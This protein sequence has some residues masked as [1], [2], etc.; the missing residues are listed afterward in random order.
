MEGARI[1]VTGGAGFIGSHLVERLAQRNSVSV[2]DDLSTG[3]LQNLAHVGGQTR[4]TRASILD[5]ETATKA[6]EGHEVVYH[7]AAKTSVPESVAKPEEYWRSNVEGTLNVL[8]A[9]VDAGVRRV[10]FA[11]SAAIYGESEVNPKLES[12]RP[13]P[14]SPYATTKMVGEFACQ[15]ISSLKGL[16]TVVVRIFNVYGPRQEPTAPYAGAIAKFSWAIA[17]K[18]PLTVY[19]DG[20]QTRDFIYV[21]DLAEAL[22]LA[23]E[24][25]VAGDTFNLGSGE[26]T[27]VNQVVQILSEI[28]ATPIRSTRKHERPGDV[29]HSLAAIDKAEKGLAFHPRTPLRDGLKKTLEFYRGRTAA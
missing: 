18:Q 4:L 22:E 27:S 1:L 28:T 24:R 20:E 19:G 10:V 3:S 14:A 13:A 5:T 12:M 2:L 11:S 7:L 25:P 17:A 21:G 9:A 8:K 6:M 29:R 16:E 15:E 23:G 26:A